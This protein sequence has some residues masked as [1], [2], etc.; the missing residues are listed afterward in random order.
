MNL[1]ATIDTTL[2]CEQQEL[3]ERNVATSKL[4]EVL[5]KGE[6]RVL[7]RVATNEDRKILEARMRRLSTGKTINLILHI[8][9][10]PVW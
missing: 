2:S 6:R 9:S 7:M 3:S 4:F 1:G 5:R 8:L 10:C